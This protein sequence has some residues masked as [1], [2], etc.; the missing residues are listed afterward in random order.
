MFNGVIDEVRIYNRVLSQAE[1]SALYYQVYPPKISGTAPWA[2][3][4]TVVCQNLTQNKQVQLPATTDG[5]WNCEAA[6]LKFN[7]GDTAK[8]IITGK[9]Y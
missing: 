4:H 2:T 5:N 7:H 3:S 9:R 1:I 8:V 6:G